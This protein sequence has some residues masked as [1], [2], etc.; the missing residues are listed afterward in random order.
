MLS[1]LKRQKIRLLAM[2]DRLAGRPPRFQPKPPAKQASPAP[3]KEP[4]PPTSPLT[5][6]D[7]L[8][9]GYRLV[10]VTMGDGT[11]FQDQRP[12]TAP[13]AVPQMSAVDW[14]LEQT[15]HLSPEDKK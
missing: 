13:S 6:W 15:K 4:S 2:K 3:A 14:I 7:A 10:K 12:S 9:R 5:V 8:D 1:E 11:V